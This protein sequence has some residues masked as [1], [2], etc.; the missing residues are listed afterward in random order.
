MAR[1]LLS[2]YAC[3]PGRGSEPGVGWTWATELAALG[4][5]VTVITRSANRQAI[6]QYRQFSLS[7]LAFLYYDLPPWIQRWRGCPGGKALYYILWQFFAARHISTTLSSPPF[8]VVHHVTY[9]S[10]RYPSFM[11][12]L[13]IPFLFGPVSGGETVPPRL[14]SGF[15]AGKGDASGYAISPTSCACLIPDAPHLP[16][17][18][19]HPGHTR[20]AF[21]HSAALAAQSCS[22]VGCGIVRGGPDRCPAKPLRNSRQLHLL[23]VGRLLEWKGDRYRSPS[24]YILQQSHPEVSLTLIGDGPARPKLAKLSQNLGLEQNVRGWLVA[25]TRRSPITTAPPISLLYPS[26]R[27]S[28]G[29]V[30][31]EA[32]A[33]G[34]PVV[35]TDLGGPGISSIPRAAARWQPRAALRINWPARLPTRC[36][37]FCSVPNRLESLSYGAIVRAR[38]LRFRNLAQSLYPD[39]RVVSIAQEA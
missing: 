6:E 21:S 37:R 1:V 33:H 31:L 8:D 36:W 30:V 24:L 23:Y 18:G 2:A 11:G 29:M 35:C 4:H 32:L 14:R 7:E 3:E 5:H 19:A 15:S 22:P 9:V 38:E 26:L 13:G 10:A 25:P 27:D 17:S 20:H 12:S 34:L 16:A 28:G 39:A